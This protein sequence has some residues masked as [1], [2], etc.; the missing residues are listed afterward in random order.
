MSKDHGKSPF[1]EKIR[2]LMRVQ[3][4]A[5]RTEQSYIE[6]IKRFILFRGERHPK[7]TGEKEVAAF[8]NSLTPSPSSI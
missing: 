8:F 5:I 2:Q 4:Y 7:E 6:W 3:H 1:L